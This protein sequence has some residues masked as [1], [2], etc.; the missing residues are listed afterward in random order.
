[1]QNPAEI[2]SV[3][4]NDAYFPIVD[5]VVQ[6]VHQYAD[7]MNQTGF[8]CV[9]TPK[10]MKKQFD[11][12]NLS[13]EVYRTPLIGLP[14]AE[15]GMPAPRIDR[16]LKQWLAD[17]NPQIFHAHSPFFEGAFASSYSKKLGIPCVATF[18][19]KYYDDVI[20]ITGS[21]TIAKIVTKRIVRFYRS[22][23]SVWACSG[24]TADT[25]RSY[26]YGGD[27]FVMD[28]G[29]SFK[30]PDNA[31][32]LR[33]KAAERFGI[34]EDKHIILF[35]GHQIWHKNLKLV[36]DTFKMLC[37]HSDDYRLLIVGNG[38]DEQ[39][40]R[41]YADSL[42]FPDGFLRFLGKIA[43][44]D[45][46]SGVYLNSDLLF[47]PSVYDNSPL[48]VR[49]AASLG[50]PSLLTE[51]SNAA[52]AVTNNETGFTAAENTVAMHGEILRIFASGELL[53]KV[54]EGARK[55]VAKPWGEI[56]PLVQEKYAEIIEKY[57]FEH[58]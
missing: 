46:L 6:T 5:G 15:Y 20:H 23:D 34:P 4:F 17:K 36:L 18:H 26:G 24:G 37:D 51:G 42:L 2:R 55:H 33:R 21:K 45:L 50:V 38:Y 8:A 3:Q 16:K 11:D 57:N 28:N 43:D 27:I 9:V 44:R 52:E 39:E 41:K 35:V 48:V 32:E 49:E 19:S 54:G 40:I 47:F 22:V 13:Y 10:P 25:L 56:V 30:Y 29:T 7:H 53:A 58:R 1:M 12:S 14:I 31:D